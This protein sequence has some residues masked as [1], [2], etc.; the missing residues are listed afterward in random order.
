MEWEQQQQSPST[1][2]RQ[3]AVGGSNSLRGLG[4]GYPPGVPVGELGS[5]QI[6][7]YRKRNVSSPGIVAP[8]VHALYLCADTAPGVKCSVRRPRPPDA[9]TPATSP[10]RPS[11]DAGPTARGP[12]A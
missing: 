4:G 11:G 12:S 2:H 6:P 10:R 8:W 9:V 3:L 1:Q 7:K 5:E